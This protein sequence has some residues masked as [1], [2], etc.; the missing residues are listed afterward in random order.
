[1]SHMSVSKS[2]EKAYQLAFLKLSD[3]EKALALVS[4]SQ[5]L[6]LEWRLVGVGY[7]VSVPV[8]LAAQ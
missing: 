2:V 3:A 8:P 1:M 5:T 6:W 7:V 4:H